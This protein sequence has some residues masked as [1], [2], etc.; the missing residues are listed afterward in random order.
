MMFDIDLDMMKE[1]ILSLRK[2]TKNMRILVV[3]DYEVLQKSIEKI[4]TSLFME[5]H[6]ASDGVEALRLYK[7]KIAKGERYDIILSD[8]AMPNMNGVTLTKEI[9]A[10]D[11]EQIILIFSAHQDSKYLL[12]LINL[13]VRRFILKPISL[14]TLLDEILWI[15]KS[16]YDAKN[17]SQKI[18]LREN[19]MYDKDTRELF[20]DGAVIKLT[21]HERLILEL[22]VSKLNQTLSNE[23]IIN[24]LYL[25]G[26]DIEL[27]NVRKVVYKLRK[28]LSNNLIE[29][30]HSIGYKIK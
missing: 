15:C 13:E 1:H 4:F 16:L 21:Q 6:V 29:N 10:I 3:E 30:I 23:E 19:V 9:R 27:S 12:E 5:V 7:E 20:I 2:Y 14:H 28:K 26:I 18:I 25:F 8:I 11:K 22:F 24:H 17:L